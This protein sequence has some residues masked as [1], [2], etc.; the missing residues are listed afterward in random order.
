M[1]FFIDKPLSFL[2]FRHLTAV[3]P[4]FYN[5]TLTLDIFTSQIAWILLGS[6]VF[7]ITLLFFNK[8]KQVG[9]VLLTLC[10]VHIAASVLTNVMKT[11]FRR[12]RPEVQLQAVSSTADFFNNQTRNYCFPSSH[13]SFYLSLLLPAAMVFRKYGTV[14]LFILS[15]IIMGRVLLNEH[16]LGDVLCSILIVFDLSVFTLNLFFLL[17]KRLHASNRKQQITPYL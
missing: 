9:F 14:F 6:F 11:E 10:F 5:F 17:D 16:Y 4:F 7:G 2:I 12:A 1:Y 8:G 15:L 13:T 3:Q